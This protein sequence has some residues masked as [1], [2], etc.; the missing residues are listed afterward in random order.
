MRHTSR[1]LWEVYETD[2]PM[3]RLNSESGKSGESIIRTARG[4]IGRGNLNYTD[5]IDSYRHVDGRTS[6]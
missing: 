5:D 1:D 2:K 3:K 4:Y 6:A